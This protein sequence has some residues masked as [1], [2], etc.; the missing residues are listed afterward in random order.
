[1]K[2]LWTFGCSHTLGHGL[3][4]CIDDKGD[5]IP[6]PSQYAWPVHLSK[7]LNIPVINNSHAGI[8]PKAVWNNIINSNIK[9]DDII[10]IMWP[11][12][13][14]RIDLLIDPSAKSN[15]SLQIQPVRAWVKEDEY[16][17]D[18]YYHTYDRWIEFHLL[19]RHI[20]DNYS[21]NNKLIQ[22]SYNVYH[23]SKGLNTNLCVD[24]TEIA[25]GMHKY[26][27]M[28]LALDN[29]HLGEQAHEDFAQDLYTEAFC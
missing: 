29:Q 14:S 3:P 5:P 2:T 18:N 12:W 8:G 4:D 19:A 11:C 16:Y 9:P 28:P 24:F 21:K 6:T 22:T 1:M 10:V 25:F 13:E 17:F 26:C 20:Q 7:L 23:K 27:A 15:H